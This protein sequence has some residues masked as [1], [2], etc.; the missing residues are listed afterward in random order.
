MRGVGGGGVVCN[1]VG[2]GVGDGGVGRVFEGVWFVVV[3]VALFVLVLLV[4]LLSLSASVGVLVIDI[5]RT[6]E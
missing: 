2:E 3:R 6:S 1:G 4:L 5:T